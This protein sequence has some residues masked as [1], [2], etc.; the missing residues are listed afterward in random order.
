MLAAKLIRAMKRVLLSANRLFCLP[1][2]T[3][4][5]SGCAPVKYA[6]NNVWIS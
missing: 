5:R 1:A 3:C 2:L 6:P 4:K